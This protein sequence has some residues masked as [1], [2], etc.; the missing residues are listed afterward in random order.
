[1]AVK[2]ISFTDIYTVYIN[3]FNIMAINVLIWSYN[4]LK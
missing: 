4:S 2:S 1:M 3:P